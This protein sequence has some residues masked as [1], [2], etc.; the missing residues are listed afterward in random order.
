MSKM[1]SF[2]LII[3]V[4][5]CSALVFQLGRYGT[6]YNEKRIGLGIPVI[7]K[8]WDRDY[9]FL[10]SEINY[11]NPVPDKEKRYHLKKRIQTDWLMNI[12]KEADYFIIE[13][14]ALAIDVIYDYKN[15][16]P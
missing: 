7:S 12:E 1:K 9:S 15:K 8:E 2:I 3:V 10:R 16:K 5:V 14:K 13:D 11:T 4:C 6:R